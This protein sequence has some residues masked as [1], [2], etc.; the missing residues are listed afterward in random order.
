MSLTERLNQDMKT[1]MKA[2]DKETLSVIRMVKASLQNEA[3]RTGNDTLS[4]DEELTVLSREV[5]Q[6]K[7]SLQEFQEAGRDDLVQKQE[8][9]LQVLKGYMPE[10]LSEEELE[11]VIKQTITEVGATSK[12]DMG[13][14]MSAVMPK[15]K[16]KTDGSLV[17]KIVN[18][19]LS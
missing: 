5:K 4:E 3:I 19:H 17:N 6:R 8:A 12:K 15:V 14:V 2:R 10:Q 16:G 13:S 1:A 7:D 9:E 11:D 18:K